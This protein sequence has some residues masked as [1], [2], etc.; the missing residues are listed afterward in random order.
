M[1]DCLFCRI[2]RKE[3]P[4]TIVYEDAKFL[5]FEDIHPK[6]P[7][8]ILLIPKTHFASLNEA[9]DEAGGL[10][11]FLL[12]SIS[13]LC[14]IFVVL[15]YLGGSY[16]LRKNYTAQP[17]WPHGLLQE[18]KF[19]EGCGYIPLDTPSLRGH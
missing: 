6:A 19:R 3:I 4:A 12:S 13:F 18:Q 5:A 11:L 8:H 14:G 15:K 9:P 17:P 10:R 7:V 2:V 1:A 16:N